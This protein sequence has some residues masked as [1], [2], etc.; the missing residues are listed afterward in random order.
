MF[1]DKQVDVTD[2]CE[3]EGLELVGQ[4]DGLRYGGHFHRDGEGSM[5]VH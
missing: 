5:Q 1:V 2:P 4:R 3:N